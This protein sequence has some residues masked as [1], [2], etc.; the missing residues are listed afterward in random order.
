MQRTTCRFL[1]VTCN[2]RGT[3]KKR[4]FHLANEKLQRIDVFSTKSLY[5]RLRHTTVRALNSWA[6]LILIHLD[7]YMFHWIVYPRYD[8]FN[9]NLK[10]KRDT[11]WKLCQVLIGDVCSF[12]MNRNRNNRIQ[13]M[14]KKKPS[15]V[16]RFP[17]AWSS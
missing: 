15:I 1:C 6:I 4:T 16:L 13:E 14:K 8:S 9:L 10:K 12:R 17:E 2:I 3:H 7:I 5:L 11:Q